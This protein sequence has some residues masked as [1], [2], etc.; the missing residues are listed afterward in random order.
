MRYNY[1]HKALANKIKEI[2]KENFPK[3][4]AYASVK[5]ELLNDDDFL[6]SLTDAIKDEFTI[7]DFGEL[8][9]S[10]DICSLVDS[11]DIG[12]YFDTDEIL[13]GI[14]NSVIADYLD[15]VDYDYRCK[16]KRAPYD[17]IVKACH[18]I[19]PKTGKTAE[20]MKKLTCEEIDFNDDNGVII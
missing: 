3:N 8:F 5:E 9:N 13:N 16:D 15:K 4:K 19:S 7:Y 1:R 12:D 2:L 20:D 17:Y 6:D 14:D 18:M 11:S 10:D